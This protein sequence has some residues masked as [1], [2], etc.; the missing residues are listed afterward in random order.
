VS[1]WRFLNSSG[2]SFFGFGGLDFAADLV[3]FV[4][5]FFVRNE[6][7]ALVAAVFF[8]RNEADFFVRDEVAIA[9][10]FLRVEL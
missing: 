10:R 9:G 2:V 4:A 6:A 1:S 5:A 3:A 8:V 7:V